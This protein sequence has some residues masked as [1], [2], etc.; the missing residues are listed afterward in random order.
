MIWDTFQHGFQW[1]ALHG[2]GYQF[3][4][5]IGSGSPLVAGVFI[6]LHKHNCHIKGCLRLQWHADPKTGHPVCKKHH[7]H[8]DHPLLRRNV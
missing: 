4:S 7:P 1:F 3:W 2:D 5:G 6:L 8:S